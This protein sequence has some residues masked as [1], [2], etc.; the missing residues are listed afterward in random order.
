M[1]RWGQQR[2][3]LAQLG[4]RSRMVWHVVN[5]E[6]RGDCGLRVSTRVNWP[7]LV[8]RAICAGR[9]SARVLSFRWS[10]EVTECGFVHSSSRGAAA[11]AMSLTPNAGVGSMATREREERANPRQSES[12]PAICESKARRVRGC[13][14]NELKE[15]KEPTACASRGNASGESS[16]KRRERDARRAAHKLKEKSLRRA[17]VAARTAHN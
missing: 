7:G 15:E 5:P 16:E 10:L 6:C 1:V 13:C 8:W 3:I 17:R 14:G 2:R 11:Y 9:A 12:Q 4:E